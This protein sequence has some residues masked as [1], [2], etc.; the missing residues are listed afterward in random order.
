L[1]FAVTLFTAIGSTTYQSFNVSNGN[2]DPGDV[3]L[4]SQ[5]SGANMYEILITSV[6]TDL[7]RVTF[8]STGGVVSDTPVFNFVVIKG[9]VA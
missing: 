4:A 7:F 5:K 2:V 9:Q 3:I 6:Q 1:T 8:R